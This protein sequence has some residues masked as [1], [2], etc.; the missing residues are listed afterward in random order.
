MRLRRFAF[1]RLAFL[2]RKPVLGRPEWHLT[3]PSSGR[4]PASCAA[5]PPPLM[6]NVR[7]HGEQYVVGTAS[8]T[9][10]TTSC[11]VRTLSRIGGSA[12]SGVKAETHSNRGFTFLCS[13]GR[14][15]RR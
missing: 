3:P 13:Y 6:S 5:W 12:P 1:V 7:Q 9:P 2:R 8:C 15:L 14:W 4:R 11:S 10:C